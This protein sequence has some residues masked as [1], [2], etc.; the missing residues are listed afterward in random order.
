[1]LGKLCGL[2]VEKDALTSLLTNFHSCFSSSHH[3]FHSLAASSKLSHF[4]HR[5]DT[6][7]SKHMPLLSVH[8]GLRYLRNC[9]SFINSS[10]V[11]T[12]FD[13]KA[14]KKRKNEWK[15]TGGLWCLLIF[16]KIIN[17][18][19]S[20]TINDFKSSTSIMTHFLVLWQANLRQIRMI[21]I[22]LYCT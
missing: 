15:G 2:T 1:M 5:A 22:L 8:L 21:Y 6:V 14:L 7:L 18:F 20:W 13:T 10:L 16:L 3:I 11:D 17:Y 4:S 9:R 12:R 19:K